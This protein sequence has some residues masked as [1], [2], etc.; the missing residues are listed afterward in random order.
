MLDRSGVVSV[1]RHVLQALFI[2]FVLLYLV[3]L[4]DLPFVAEAGGTWSA[5]RHSPGAGILP[6]PRL[7]FLH[8]LYVGG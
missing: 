7:V 5:D 4:F 2:S 3:A 8:D 1:V 6:V